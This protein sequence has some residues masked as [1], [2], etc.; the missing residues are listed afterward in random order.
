M[1]TGLEAQITPG[2]VRAFS[3]SPGHKAGPRRGSRGVRTIALGVLLKV[4]S[5]TSAAGST[6]P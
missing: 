2:R 6:D 5:V 3:A 1:L 4:W